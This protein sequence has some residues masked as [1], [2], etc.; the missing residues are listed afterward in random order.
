MAEIAGLVLGG[1]PLIFLALD[2]YQ[3][4]LEQGRNYCKYNDMLLD[5]RTEV[6]VQQKQFY[7]TIE[8]LGLYE[9]TYNE[10]DQY[11]QVHF[12]EEYMQFARYIKKMDTT[13]KQL[14]EKLEIDVQDKVGT[15]SRCRRTSLTVSKAVTKRF[16]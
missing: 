10:L 1:I 14:M 13:V 16:L 7:N 4:C 3:E 11:L 2:K 5:I 12:P 9:P 15:V 6:F 8:L